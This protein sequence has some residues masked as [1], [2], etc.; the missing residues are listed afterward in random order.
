MHLESFMEPLNYVNIPVS[1]YLKPTQIKQ[2]ETKVHESI[3]I[4]PRLLTIKYY[5]AP[6]EYYEWNDD[7]L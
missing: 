4:M 3:Q 1:I 7:I 2:K 5:S 6:E